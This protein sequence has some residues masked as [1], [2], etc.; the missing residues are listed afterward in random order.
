MEGVFRTLAWQVRGRFADWERGASL[1][2]MK[3]HERSYG[4][5]SVADRIVLGELI[6]RANPRFRKPGIACYI[7]PSSYR[8][9]AVRV[10]LPAGEAAGL[11][12]RC[13]RGRLLERGIHRGAAIFLAAEI[14]S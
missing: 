11:S 14:G 2:V 9:G 13:F 5:R 7:S 10:L 8:H 1:D 3:T 4:F 6:F 12:P